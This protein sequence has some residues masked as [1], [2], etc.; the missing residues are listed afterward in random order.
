MALKPFLLAGAVALSL[1]S[2]AMAAT[3]NVNVSYEQFI[4]SNGLRVVVHEDRKAPI[5]AVSIWYHVGSK[6]EPAGKT[7]F[8]HLFEHL[9]FNGSEN[10]PGE[11]FEPFEKVGA[12]GMNGTTWLDRTNYFE[13]VPTPALDMALWMESDRMGHLLGAIDQET[14]DEQR[15]VVQNEKRQRDNQPYGTAQYRLQYGVFPQGHPYHHTTIGSMA[16]LDAAALDDVKGWF[17]EYYG[18]ANTVLVLAGDIDAKTAI[19]KVE[20]YFGDIK[21]GPALPHLKSWVP[22]K[23]ENVLETITDQ[24]PQA[25]IY[26]RWAIPGRSTKDKTMLDMAALILASSKRAPFYKRLVYKK[27]LATDV[28]VRVEPHELA[29]IFSI[30]VTAKPGVDLNEIEKEIDRIIK[31]FIVTG[32]SHGTLKSTKTAFH[33]G[34]MR[35]LERVGGFGGKAATL[36][37]GALYADDPGFYKTR[38]NWINDASTIAV[39][40][41]FRKWIG[42][43]YYQL[44]VIPFGKHKAAKSTVDRSKG[45]PAVGALPDLIF[46]AVQEATL[47]NGMKLVFAERHTIPVINVALQFDAGFASD[48]GSKLG[49]SSFAMA[50]L[51]DGAGR[52]SALALDN[53]LNKHGAKLNTSSELDVSTVTLSALKENL[54]PSL[55]IM[56]DVVLRPAFAQDEI[57][58][59][60]KLWIAKIAQEKSQP[61]QL[62]LRLLPPELYGKDHAY[63]V[64]FTGSGT[65]QSITL[66][67]RDDLVAFKDNWLRPDNATMFVVGDTTLEAILPELNRVFGG[68]KAPSIPKPTKNIS[69][70]SLPKTGKVVLIDKKYSPQTLI[71]AGEVTPPETSPDALAI[72]TMN[73]IL[74]GQFTARV[75]MNLREDK[76]WSYGVLTF[77]QTAKGQRPWMVYAPVQ[78]DKTSESLAELVREFEEFKGKRPATRDELAKVVKN[79]TNRLPG[80]YETASAVLRSLMTSKTFGHPYNYPNILKDKLLSM[81]TDEVNAQSKVIVPGKLTWIIVGDI[82]KIRPGIEALNLGPL[83]IWDADGKKLE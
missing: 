39:Q 60:R 20:K 54:A 61:R 76:H 78:T 16:D 53:K 66:I 6:D 37:E 2:I 83:E 12:T 73:G 44:K 64:P 48:Q 32:P 38:L 82:E 52:L 27:Q 30:R 22:V 71:L 43:P 13:T 31:K 75:N 57:E 63:G 4:L 74:G 3:P 47:D 72:D 65:V 56:A 50:L 33:I 7:G 80:K 41:A 35:E 70:V 17:N 69:M 8:A 58:R 67:T 34:A 68:W 9:M 1:S 29:S 26:R 18:A 21:A 36:A 79:N 81:T 55:N 46:P 24:V 25:R 19:A 23:S 77:M 51:D 28:S 40:D 62:A 15:G 59:A 5:V 10:H 45:L 49:T 11:F 14:L 42:K